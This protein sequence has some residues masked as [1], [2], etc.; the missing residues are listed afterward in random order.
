MTPRH[1]R[2][3]ETFAAPRHGYG[4]KNP[5]GT[6]SKWTLEYSPC[7]SELSWFISGLAM[8][9]GRY[10]PLISTIMLVVMIVVKMVNGGYN[11]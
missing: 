11:G 10:K 3:Q 6:A 5:M 1:H 8:V 7:L 2:S 9:Y 4:Q